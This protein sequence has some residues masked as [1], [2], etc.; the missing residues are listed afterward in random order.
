MMHSNY[1]CGTN[2]SMINTTANAYSIESLKWLIEAGADEVI[3][4]LP[5]NRFETSAKA[6]AIPQSYSQT[7]AN[8]SRPTFNTANIVQNTMAK[9]KTGQE[10]LGTNQAV[11]AARTLCADATTF[12]QITDIINR[13]DGCPSLKNT[14]AN[15]VIYRGAS[16]PEILCIGHAPNR[17]D[18]QNGQPFSGNNEILLYRMFKAINVKPETMGFTN[19]VFWAPPGGR[20][21][22][23]SEFSICKVF[24]DKIIKILSPKMIILFGGEISKNMLST[25]SGIGKLHGNAH[26]IA[27]IGGASIPCMPLHHPDYILETPVSKP[28]VWNDLKILKQSLTQ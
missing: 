17:N 21:V 7:F 19:G 20:S 13:F 1:I 14:A 25:N 11:A 16:N 8:A 5:I 6:Q 9:K 18:E 26:I 22:S 24:L 2:A 10:M 23:P 4:E 12:E 27:T 3:G 15:T 28:I